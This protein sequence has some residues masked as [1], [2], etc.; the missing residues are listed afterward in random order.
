MNM[1]D[2]L[3]IIILLS[4]CYVLYKILELEDNSNFNYI[5]NLVL[6]QYIY[7]NFVSDNII[8][9]LNFLTYIDIIINILIIIDINKYKININKY[10]I[11]KKTC[12]IMLID[13]IYYLHIINL[14]FNL[15]Y[16][17]S[18]NIKIKN[19]NFIKAV[20]TI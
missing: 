7:F 12:N 3:F 1:Y 10:K 16:L 20:D 14:C 11:E 17:S 5:L 6:I 18:N 13:G 15:Y 4:R 8:Y 19:K 2:N 9:N